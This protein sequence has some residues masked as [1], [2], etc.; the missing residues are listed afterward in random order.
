MSI[1]DHYCPN[2]CCNG[3][4][5]ECP[6]GQVNEPG[7]GTVLFYLVGCPVVDGPG[8]VV[9]CPEHSPYQVQKRLVTTLTY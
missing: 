6:V 7:V 8:Q 9:H 1:N 3:Q 5:K 4:D 2:D